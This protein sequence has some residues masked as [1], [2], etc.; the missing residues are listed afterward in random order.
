MADDD[1][2]FRREGAVGRITLNRPAALNALTLEMCASILRQLEEWAGAREIQFVVIDAVPGRAFCAGGDMRAI[3]QWANAK[4]SR[5]LEFFRTE[6]R[7]NAAIKRFAKPYVALMNG[8]V[9]GGGAGISVHGSHRVATENT[10]FAMPETAIWCSASERSIH[11][12]ATK[13]STSL[14]L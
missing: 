12:E 4:D 9:M 7:M 14:S 3:W 1:I 13:R 5:A 2:I 11:S 6:Y 8:I 10:V